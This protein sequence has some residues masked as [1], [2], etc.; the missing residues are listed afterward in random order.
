MDLYLLEPILVLDLLKIALDMDSLETNLE[1][2]LF[3]VKKFYTFLHKN[4]NNLKFKK[5][6]TDKKIKSFNKYLTL[7]GISIL[8]D[9]IK[10]TITYTALPYL[11]FIHRY[12]SSAKDQHSSLGEHPHLYDIKY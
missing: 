7:S 5:H 11:N 3:R 6:N 8:L 2:N 4:I 10:F 9:I 1:Q 12:S